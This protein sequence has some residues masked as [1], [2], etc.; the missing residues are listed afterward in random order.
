MNPAAERAN[1]HEAE[2]KQRLVELLEVRE[3][4]ADKHGQEIE[5]IK[6]RHLLDAA[7]EIKEVEIVAGVESE[8]LDKSEEKIR[9]ELAQAR[10]DSVW[11]GSIVPIPDSEFAWRMSEKGFPFPVTK[12]GE[13]LSAESF[14]TE[15]P[16][17][18]F[19]S[20]RYLTTNLRGE[21]AE[22]SADEMSRNPDGPDANQHKN[23][24]FT[25]GNAV[26]EDVTDARNSE[27]DYREEHIDDAHI[28]KRN[29]DEPQ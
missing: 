23:E 10:L 21:T 12:E 16:R 22:L 1:Q 14:E 20:A 17:S 26:A 4:F 27:K 19:A 11:Q 9:Q 25:C 15:V 3:N 2:T 28:A 29:A 24:L 6:G 13:I 18:S 5:A 7:E 8:M